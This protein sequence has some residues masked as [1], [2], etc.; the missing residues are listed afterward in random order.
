MIGCLQAIISASSWKMVGVYFWRGE[1]NWFGQQQQ[2]P[3]RLEAKNSIPHFL[4]WVPRCLFKFQFKGWQLI[5]RRELVTSPFNKL[6]NGLVVPGKF[7]TFTKSVTTGQKLKEE[8]THI[9]ELC[10]W[11]DILKI[12]GSDL[13][14][15]K[16]FFFT[17]STVVK[18]WKGKNKVAIR[19]FYWYPYYLRK[20]GGGEGCVYFKGSTHLIS[21]L[22]S[23]CL[24]GGGHLW[25]H[26][27]LFKE[28][29]MVI[30][31]ALQEIYSPFF[32]L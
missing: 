26:G 31:V 16:L 13:T 32:H 24:F 30:I 5:W 3:K 4:E 6:E 12:T 19:C 22:R 18:A 9:K 21:G 27:H 15:K 10:K 1:E 17:N 29:I 7:T 25:E 11:M 8:V 2:L 23:W 20:W 28:M 14:E